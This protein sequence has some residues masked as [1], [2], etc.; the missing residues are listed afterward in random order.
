MA[1]AATLGGG[2][3]LLLKGKLKRHEAEGADQ[4]EKSATN[5]KLDKLEESDE[6]ALSAEADDRLAEGQA[7]AVEMATV[8]TE[9]QR[10][11]VQRRGT[12][13]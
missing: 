12:R 3:L 5:S 8:L 4:R 7:E 13:K 2:I 9:K 10:F 6:N 11:I 1:C